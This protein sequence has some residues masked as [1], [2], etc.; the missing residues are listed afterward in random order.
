[1]RSLLFFATISAASALFSGCVNSGTE[2]RKMVIHPLDGGNF[3]VKNLYDLPVVEKK[4]LGQILLAD[5]FS[6]SRDKIKTD[7]NIALFKV[8]PGK[9][10]AIY[11]IKSP[12][13]LISM[14]GNGKIQANL[15]AIAMKEGQVVYIPADTKLSIINDTPKEMIFMAVGS[16]P[17][18][19]EQI[20]VT[21]KPPG[22]NFL[23]NNADST[24]VTQTPGDEHSYEQ[25]PV[26]TTVRQ[27]LNLD[28]YDAELEKTFKDPMSS[29]KSYPLS[30][31]D[32]S[33]INLD[34]LFKEDPEK[35]VPASMQEEEKNEQGEALGSTPS[36]AS[37][38]DK[39]LDALIEEQSKKLMPSSTQN[40]GKVE[41]ASESDKKL[42]ALIE[43]QSKKLMPS[44][45]QKEGKAEEVTEGEKKF[46]AL[47]EEQSKKLTPS[48][49]QKGEK[50]E[51]ATEKEKKLDAIIKEQSEKLVPSTPQKEKKTDLQ[52]TKEL[53][54][55]ESSDLDQELDLL[56]EEQPE[57]LIPSTPQK[58]KKTDLQQTQELT[59]SE[60]ETSASSDE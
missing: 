11:Q 28:K 6:S 22:K 3:I 19:L 10:S 24:K 39:K 9:G 40:G 34:K 7:Y 16:P 48:S 8:P 57:T 38:S 50:T 35:L 46:N 21:G 52:Q 5:V 47:M 53:T 41:K 12:Q 23:N 31:P 55:S 15:D 36:K 58:G 43:E 13:C 45:T 27:Q 42:D 37:E 51:K 25:A 4:Q 44:S 17:F 2:P 59:P 32:D 56:T 49:T 60:K 18:K 30:I 1:M 26:P 54:P 14:T 33:E 20:K 29:P